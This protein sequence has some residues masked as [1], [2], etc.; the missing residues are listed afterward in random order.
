ML[1]KQAQD[2]CFL[3]GLLIVTLLKGKPLYRTQDVVNTAPAHHYLCISK[4]GYRFQLSFK[5]YKQERNS[6]EKERDEESEK[7]GR[8]K[9]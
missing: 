9:R 4:R 2:V 6:R 1:K 3:R 5:G 7:E 8:T